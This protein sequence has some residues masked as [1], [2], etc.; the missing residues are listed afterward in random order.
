MSERAGDLLEKL[1]EKGKVGWM[2]STDFSCELGHALGGNK[3]FP[4]A[5]DCT[6]N[7]PCIQDPDEHWPCRAQR[8][9]VFDADLLDEC[10]A[11]LRPVM[12]KLVEAGDSLRGVCDMEGADDTVNRWD[13]ALAEYRKVL[14]DT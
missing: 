2:D 12:E 10:L 5:E 4:D 6:K 1:S 8:V 3:I 14:H 13:T 9:I 7:H 11:Q